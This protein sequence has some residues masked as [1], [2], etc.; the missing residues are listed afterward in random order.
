MIVI[1]HPDGGPKKIVITGSVVQRAD[2]TR[3]FYTSDTSTGSSGSPV[4]DVG[5]RVVA[6]HQR[7]GDLSKIT[8]SYQNNSGIPLEYIFAQPEFNDRSSGPVK[9]LLGRLLGADRWMTRGTNGL[10]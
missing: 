6:L 1:Q 2:K 8:K 10:R 3:L 4:F 5:W 9:R 7:A